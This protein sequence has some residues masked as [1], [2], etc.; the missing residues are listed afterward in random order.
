MNNDNIIKVGK[1]LKWRNTYESQKVY[2]QENIV[3]LCGCVFR[4]KALQVQGKSP[5]GKVD[6]QGHISFDNM[7]VW[8]VVV[9]MLYYYNY[10]IDC[11]NLVKETNQYIKEVEAQSREQGARLDVLE[12][13]HE[14]DMAEV[15]GTLA[16]HNLRIASNE[17]AILAMQLDIE[18]IKNDVNGLRADVN[19][20]LN[21]IN[22]INLQLASIF[23]SIASQEQR[24]NEQEAR[25]DNQQ[26]KIE[27]LIA[28]YS[29]VSN[30]SWSNDFYWQDDDLWS[31]G[32]E[33]EQGNKYVEDYD[34][35]SQTLY[36]KENTYLYN[37][38]TGELT[39]DV[40][41]YMYDDDTDTL[42]IN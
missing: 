13:R 35:A 14:E 10:T 34:A 36:L 6:E 8:D 33:D 37:E 20:S 11:M 9:D 22:S 7:D 40:S 19:A 15:R 26:S 23:K 5:I 17:R 32:Y 27:M 38:E 21:Q 4:C 30:G 24:L 16:E 39:A 25:L 42:Y 2:Y 41:S 28:D 18:G 12:V 31:D 29:V 1:A 3:T